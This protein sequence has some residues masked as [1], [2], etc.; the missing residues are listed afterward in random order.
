MTVKAWLEGGKADLETLAEMLSSGDIRVVHD[1]DKDAYYLTAPTIDNPDQPG[2]FNVPAEALIGRVN[3]LARTRSA[4]YR[5][6]KLTTHYT[7]ADG[8]NR[9][10]ITGTFN[11]SLRPIIGFLVGGGD[12]V[13]IVDPPSPWPDRLTLAESKSDVAEVFDIMGRGEL[14]GWVELYKVHEIIRESIKP[15]KIYELGWADRTTDSAFTGSAN[16]PGVSGSDARHARMDGAPKHTMT[17]DEGREYI[18]RLV[19]QWLDHLD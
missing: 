17:I 4:R 9:Q 12:G 18:S 16:L 14:L 1:A 8:E 5:P 19:T 7:D 2:R 10:I 13:T 11:V 15:A 6:V 3:G